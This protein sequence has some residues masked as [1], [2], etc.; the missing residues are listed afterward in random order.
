MALKKKA[1]PVPDK[2]IQDAFS[3]NRGY[4][5]LERSNGWVDYTITDRDYY[6]M[7][8]GNLPDDGRTLTEIAE[9]LADGRRLKVTGEVSFDTVLVNYVNTNID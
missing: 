3:T 2:N 7:E 8:E 5:L 6:L 9:G 4:M 1:A